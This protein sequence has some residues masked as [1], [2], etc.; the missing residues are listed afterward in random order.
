MR[1]RPMRGFSVCFLSA[2][3]LLGGCSIGA[4]GART[5]LGIGTHLDLGKGGHGGYG[6]QFCPPGQDKKANC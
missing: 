6:G 4:P 5:G 2:V 3:L 1:G